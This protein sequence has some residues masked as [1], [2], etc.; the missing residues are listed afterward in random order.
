MSYLYIACYFQLVCV[1]LPA[2]YTR[3]QIE[4]PDVS[5]FLMLM[6]HMAIMYYDGHFNN[7]DWP[8]QTNPAYM[9]KPEVKYSLLSFSLLMNFSSSEARAF[10]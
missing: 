10:Y 1:Y 2:A 3:K 7:Q 5:E 8:N 9:L 6:I 4:S